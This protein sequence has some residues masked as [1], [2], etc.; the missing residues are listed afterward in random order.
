MSACK[1]KH[2]KLNHFVTSYQAV[3]EGQHLL[4]I[5][6]AA[7]NKQVKQI[8]SVEYIYNWSDIAGNFFV[9]Y[10]EH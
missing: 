5:L 7:G 8:R 1:M 9:W 4:Q 10:T 6:L 2:P 3:E